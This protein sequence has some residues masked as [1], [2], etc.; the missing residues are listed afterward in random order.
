MKKIAVA[1][2][3]LTLIGCSNPERD[4]KVKDPQVVRIG[5]FDSCDV[6]FVDRGYQELSFYIAKCGSTTT[7]TSNYTVP[8]GKTRVFKRNTAV[9]DEKQLDA[10]IGE[11]R[12][13]LKQL[14]VQKSALSKLTPE[15][16]KALNVDDLKEQ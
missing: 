4:A 8:Q 10:S 5:A 12:D 11:M 13:N 1:L 3:V 6:S 7:T 2:S 15:E 16:R 9:I 14:E